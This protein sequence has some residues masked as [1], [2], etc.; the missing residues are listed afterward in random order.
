[1]AFEADRLGQAYDDEHRPLKRAASPA[2]ATS[3]SK[4]SR[5]PSGAG[6]FAEAVGL[7]VGYVADFNVHRLDILRWWHVDKLSPPQLRERC[8]QQLG[9]TDVNGNLCQWVKRQKLPQLK[10]NDEIRLHACGDYILQALDEGQS[11]HEIR[12][13]VWKRWLVALK[14]QRL[15]VYIEYRRK[16]A[17][18][19]ELNRVVD[20]Y[21]NEE[22]ILDDDY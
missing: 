16:L 7:P 22:G 4:R 17:Q 3:V 11:I 5:S 19:N 8:I 15:N 10:T 6:A 18:Y 1:M 21:Y 2:V 20:P 9:F 12:D 13:T 14:T